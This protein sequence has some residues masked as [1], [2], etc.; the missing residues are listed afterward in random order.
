MC[1]GE[2][3]QGQPDLHSTSM[4]GTP[5]YMPPEVASEAAWR[6]AL[7]SR[8]LAGRL[9]PLYASLAGKLAPMYASTAQCLASGRTAAWHFVS[10]AGAT[11][12]EMPRVLWPGEVRMPTVV[13]RAL[14]DAPIWLPPRA[15][16]WVGRLGAAG[17]AAAGDE[18]PA[19]SWEQIEVLM[20]GD[21]DAEGG[22]SA[23]EEEQ[24]GFEGSGGAAPAMA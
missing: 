24:D 22:A 20:R 13:R 12:A 2:W 1:L 4:I 23:W 16:M 10:E 9:T 7:A 8:A 11:I 14:R 15:Q 17:L 21:A 19:V 18:P 6:L 5:S 3:D